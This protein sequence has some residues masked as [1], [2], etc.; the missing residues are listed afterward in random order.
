MDLIGSVNYIENRLGG[1]KPNQ[2]KEKPAQKNI[3]K[4]ASDEKGN[5][6]DHNQPQ[7]EYDL[8]LGRVI[9]TTA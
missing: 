4:A 5:Q 2:D 1:R 8:R 7:T 6:A 3:R 9:D